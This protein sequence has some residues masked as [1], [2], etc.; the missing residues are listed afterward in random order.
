MIQTGTLQGI[1]DGEMIYYAWYELLPNT[2]VRIHS[3]HVEPGDKMAASVTLVDENKNLWLVQ[4]H[5][6]TK[7]ESYSR[8]FSY[9]SSR[10]SAE[11]IVERPSI[12]GK[13]TTLA[14]FSSATFTDCQATINYIT[15]T[16]NTYPG[17][18]LVMYSDEAKLVGV[19]QLSPDGSSFTID[20][21]G[22][23]GNQPHSTSSQ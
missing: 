14:D 23:T 9:S 8:N 22:P 12:S 2:A 3:L 17:Y 4:I 6:L 10:L 1:R 5:D 15:G 20:Y 16:I 21:L 18:K 13:V 7:G 19:S 11:W